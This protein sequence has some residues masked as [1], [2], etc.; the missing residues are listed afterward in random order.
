MSWFNVGGLA[1]SAYSAYNANENA[2]DANDIAEEGNA[3]GVGLLSTL[4]PYQ[5]DIY[6]KLNEFVLPRVGEG[7]EKYTGDFASPLSASETLGIDKL[8][9]YGTGD[10]NPN[11]TKGVSQYMGLLDSDEEGITNRFNETRLP[12][13]QNMFKNMVE[14]AVRESFVGTGNIFSTDR[15]NATTQAATD[16]YGKAQ[17]ELSETI[18][19]ERAGARSIVPY[20]SQVIGQEAEFPLKQSAALMAGGGLERSITQK[21]LEGEISEFYR[22][23]PELSPV[24]D[25][26]MKLLG[27]T[28]QAA[29]GIPSKDG[30]AQGSSPFSSGMGSNVSNIL[31]MLMNN[32]GGTS[33]G[34]TYDTNGF[35]GGVTGSASVG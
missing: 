17:N 5:K 11:I 19:S 15:G 22:T 27:E 1:I 25:I 31:S 3:G 35:T 14:P 32:N 4:D 18:A 12:Q 24:L 28:T 8:N 2:K 16:F 33:G 10:I 6:K 34:N 13:Y 30:S 20:M 26:A 7:L 9:A 29:Y 21:N 23:Q